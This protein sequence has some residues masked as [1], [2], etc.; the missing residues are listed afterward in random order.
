MQ[1]RLSEKIGVDKLSSEILTPSRR[2]KSRPVPG[3][4]AEGEFIGTSKL[5]TGL[6]F[7][8]KCLNGRRNLLCSPLFGNSEGS[9]RV[10]A[11]IGS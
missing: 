10:K 5:P 3:L 4:I 7:S 8:S 2:F 1:F 6:F 9:L 11:S